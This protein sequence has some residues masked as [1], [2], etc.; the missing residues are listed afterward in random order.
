MCLRR[1]QMKKIKSLSK[2]I[3][4]LSKIIEDIKKNQMEILEVE[5]IITE[6]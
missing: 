6:I 2:E 1:Q 3:E 5:N 4:S